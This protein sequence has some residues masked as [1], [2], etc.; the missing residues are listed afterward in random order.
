MRERRFQNAMLATA[1]VDELAR[2]SVIGEIEFQPTSPDDI[3]PYVVRFELSE[4]VGA[5]PPTDDLPEGR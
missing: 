5:S 3:L 1:Y 4:D 2:M